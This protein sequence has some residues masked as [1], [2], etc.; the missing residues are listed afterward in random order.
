MGVRE[1]REKEREQRRLDILASARAVFLQYGIE[2]TSMDRIAQEAELAKGTLYLYFRN[3]EEL[4]LALI[5]EHL[6]QLA[7]LLEEVTKR[8]LS[9]QQ[10]LLGIVQEFYSFSRGNDFF[11]KVMMQMRT[12]HFCEPPMETSETV[13]Q[14]R[15]ANC[16]MTRIISDIVEEGRASGVFKI[17]R[18]VEY[19]VMEIIVAMKGAT[20]VMKNGMFPPE[21]HKP[22]VGRVLT[23]V[24]CLLI[25]GLEGG[26]TAYTQDP[27]P[28]LSV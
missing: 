24:A 21:W 12:E 10:K 11:Y 18:P 28:V 20:L 3:K 8:S 9:P 13:Q 27:V 15:S 23:D 22:D 1:R 5:T 16:Q 6:E 4:V 19:V 2:Q 14:Y 7:T 26:P 25:R 17:D